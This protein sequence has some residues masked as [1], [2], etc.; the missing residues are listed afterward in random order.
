V[1]FADHAEQGLVL[2]RAVDHPGGVEDLVAAVFGIGLGEH[3][4]FD[5]GRVAAGLG[6]DVEQ[7][8]DFVVGQRQ[9]ERAVGLDQRSFAAFEHVDRSKRLRREMAEQFAG[10]SQSRAAP[11]RSC[12]RAAGRRR[13]S[14]RRR[15]RRVHP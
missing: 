5:V 12:G 6:E 4:Q 8:I 11:I 7:V 1:G 14:F 2:G 10:A 9:A 15:Q 13:S 3:H